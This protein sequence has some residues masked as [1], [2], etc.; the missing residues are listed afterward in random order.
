MKRKKTAL[1][2]LVIP[3]LLLTLSACT[4]DTNKGSSSGTQDFWGS[5]T[6]EK[7]YS[8]D[9]KYYAL[10]TV[11]QLENNSLR[12]VKV[13]VCLTENDEP[14]AEFMTARAW[15]FWGIC[16]ERDSYNIWVQSGDME[17]PCFEYRDGTWQK[18]PDMMT[19]PSYIIGRWDKTY[20]DH[21]E[22][23]G[24]IYVSPTD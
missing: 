6:A 12:M 14:A 16:W 23:W 1:V 15:D 3:I 2:C 8:C 20:R 18:N 11:E 13:T 17:V 9:R 24:S 7:T 10:Q 19:P 5:Y 22:L 4:F 21:P